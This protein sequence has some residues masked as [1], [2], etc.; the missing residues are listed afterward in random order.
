MSLLR[1]SEELKEV[2]QEA[3]RRSR[4]VDVQKGEVRRLREELQKEE[5]K[6]TS[7][8]RE[9]QSLSSHIKQLSQELEELCSRHQRTG[10]NHSTAPHF[11]SSVGPCMQI[12]LLSQ[13]NC[14]RFLIQ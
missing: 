3:A 6:T 2:R 10:S 12:D 1:Q 13:P 4:E 7:A 5:E 8:L 9:K 14:T 11:T